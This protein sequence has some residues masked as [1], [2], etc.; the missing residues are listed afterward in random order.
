MLKNSFPAARYGYTEV[1]FSPNKSALAVVN[2]W[3][4]VPKSSG[5]GSASWGAGV[6]RN[7]E[8]MLP[9]P[10][11]PAEPPDGPSEGAACRAL[12]IAFVVSGGNVLLGSG[13]AFAFTKSTLAGE[14]LMVRT[15]RPFICRT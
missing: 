8:F 9:E 5:A 14:F 6:P 11:P 10:F 7:T 3:L 13:M 12:I 1:V 15:V 4:L 2:G